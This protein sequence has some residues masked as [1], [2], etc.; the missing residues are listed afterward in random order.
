MEMSAWLHVEASLN[1][2]ASSNDG[3]SG[4]LATIETSLRLLH[5]RYSTVYNM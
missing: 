4:M 2:E 3:S 5:R 1:H